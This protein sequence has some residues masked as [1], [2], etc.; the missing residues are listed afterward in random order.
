MGKRAGIEVEE[1]PVIVVLP[2]L[3]TQQ[4]LHLRAQVP[5]CPQT[6]T[7]PKTIQQ[8]KK[9]S[10]SYRSVTSQADAAAAATSGGGQRWVWIRIQK[11]LS[12]QCLP[13]SRSQCR[14]L[15]SSNAAAGGP[16]CRSRSPPPPL[17]MLRLR[18]LEMP[19]RG[20]QGR[21]GGTALLLGGGG[22]GGCVGE[23]EAL[24]LCAVM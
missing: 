3:R 20:E 1:S 4:V 11:L 18:S 23:R 9:K 7:N 6:A 13:P 8:K 24:R 21:G 19:R 17:E 10:K 16:R 12:I 22:G 2:D 15:P 5:C 14:L